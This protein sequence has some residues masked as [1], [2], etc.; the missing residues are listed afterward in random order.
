MVPIRQLTAIEWDF[1]AMDANGDGVTGIADVSWTKRIKKAGGA[2]AAMTA[3]ITERENG[4]YSFT[5]G[6]GHNDTLGCLSI[7]FSATGV[8]RVNLQFLVRAR[9][10]DD[11]AYPATSGRSLD[12]SAT[13]EVTVAAAPVRTAVGLAAANLDT[14]LDAIPTLAEMNSS[15]TAALTTT[16]IA[17]VVPADGTR[18]TI[19]QAL[20]MLTQFMLERS[21]SGTTLTVR[22]PDG[23]TALMTLTLNDAT[24]PT[25]ITRAT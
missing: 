11:L 20:Y 6:T 21:V 13:G 14:Q 24:N 18:P 2:F 16:V 10:I 12:V 3:T 15:L 7:S 22:K 25:T 19:S 1:F 9:S 23:T 8:K 5:L 17:D 4:W